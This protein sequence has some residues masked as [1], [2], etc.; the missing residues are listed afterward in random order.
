MRCR[1]YKV[2]ENLVAAIFLFERNRIILSQR[3]PHYYQRVAERVFSPLLE[4]GEDQGEAG[5]LG[6]RS[7]IYEDGRGGV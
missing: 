5:R 2:G 1:P 3:S 4:A 6:D 7:G